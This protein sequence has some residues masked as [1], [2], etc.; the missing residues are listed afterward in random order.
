MKTGSDREEYFRVS[1]P[2]DQR[3][4]FLGITSALLGYVFIYAVIYG[5]GVLGSGLS[6]H[7]ALLA[8]LT[9]ALILGLLAAA[10]GSIAARTG[11]SFGLLIRYSFGTWGVWFP[12]IL[13]PLIAVVWYGITVSFVSSVSVT[14]FGG[15]YSLWAL[16]FGVLFW[17]SAYRGIRTMVYISYA[18]VPLCII[19]GIVLIG[20]AV[21]LEGGLQ[22]LAEK[23]PIRPIS[24]ATGV[25]VA[26]G[27]FILGATTTSLD[28]LRFAK[29]GRQGG[30]AAFLSVGLGA[31]FML[32]IG[33]FGLKAANTSDIVDLGKAVGL[34]RLSILLLILLSIDTLDK[35]LYSAS[36]TVSAASGISRSRVVLVAGLA[37]VLLGFVKSINFI[38]P[39]L[40]IL[41]IALPSLAGVIIAD[42]WLVQRKVYPTAARELDSSFASLP[43]VN[44]SGAAMWIAGGISG[45]YAWAYNL[46]MPPAL[47][48][49][50]VSIIGHYLLSRLI[51]RLGGNNFHRSQQSM[52]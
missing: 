16:A 10:G 44:Y 3:K 38:V 23:P 24:F 52:G 20:K 28:L 30:W 41:G 35:T 17:I 19:M 32:L 48:G 47:L 12:S 1:V 11:L 34:Y 31:L 45:Y 21:A 2:S 29:S 22:M 33:I 46:R 43:T 5:G 18:T 42:Y 13:Q 27:T 40:Q 14:A 37:G 9:A 49:L 50:C 15:N 7:D 26:I 39:W 6:L 4:S 8:A 36:L 25:I 51:H